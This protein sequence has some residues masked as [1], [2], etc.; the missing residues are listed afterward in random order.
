MVVGLFFQKGAILFVNVRV[1]VCKMLF[2]RCD[3]DAWGLGW[4]CRFEL[5]NALVCVGD[6][7]LWYQRNEV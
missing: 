1:W 6:G 3:G 5:D 2:G 4:G 7:D